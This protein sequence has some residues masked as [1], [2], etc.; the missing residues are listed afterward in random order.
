M[1]LDWSTL[2]IQII[3]FLILV[4]ILKRFLY[5]P[6]LDVIA[7]RRA[8]IEQTLDE[9]RTTR[10]AADAD[11]QHYENRLAEWESER[12]VERARLE[13]ELE[14]ERARQRTE[15]DHELA[16]E[17]QRHTALRERRLD[18]LKRQAEELAMERA[19]TFAASLLGGL[20]SAELDA[21][22]ATLLLAELD[23][24][25]EAQC[26]AIAAAAGTASM[27]PRLVSATALPEPL[28]EQLSTR[29]REKLGLTAPLDVTVDPAL[30]GGLRIDIG[31]WTLAACLRDELAFFQHGVTRTDG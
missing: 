22:I 10:E 28:L 3:N 9:A 14:A 7:R 13:E 31:P 20:A 17:R 26:A 1:E 24:L 15:L 12:A 4:W 25:P 8:A 11:R 27:R 16:D 29:L 18:E 5:H 6:V 30:L 21:R 2:L 23:T 19:T